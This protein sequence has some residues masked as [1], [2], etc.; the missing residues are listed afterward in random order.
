MSV[1]PHWFSTIFGFYNFA[2]MFNAGLAFMIILL[3]YLRRS[4]FLPELKNDHLHELGRYLFAFTT[5]W[6]YIWFC[7][8][9]LIWYANL[10]EETGYYLLRHFGAFGVLTVVNIL[11]NW[12]IPF[13]ILLFRKSKRTEKPLI[14]ASGIVLI[15]HWTDLYMMIFPPL[16]PENVPVFGLLEIGVFIGIAGIICWTV[17]GSL[18]KWGLIPKNDPYLEESLKLKT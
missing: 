12:L 6:V 17:L 15:G 1:E 18:S 11:L 16:L 10:P 3:I 5:F 8:H 14:L 2:G 13:T 9:M 4:G 7:Q